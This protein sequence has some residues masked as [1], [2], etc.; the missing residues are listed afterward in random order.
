MAAVGGGHGA[1]FAASV[2]CL[3]ASFG[4]NLAKTSQ[5]ADQL[6][7]G[8]HSITA[9]YGGDANFAGSTSAVLSQ[10]VTGKK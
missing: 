2:R 4:G 1:T 5:L 3:E 8:K 10:T 9:S 6:G 7:G